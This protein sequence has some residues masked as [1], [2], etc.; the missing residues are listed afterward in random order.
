MGRLGNA[1]HRIVRRGLVG[2]RWPIRHKQVISAGL[3]LLLIVI[4]IH[5]LFDLPHSRSVAGHGIQ[6][7]LPVIGHTSYQMVF[8][9]HV[10]Q[11]SI[12]AAHRAI[13]EVFL[14]LLC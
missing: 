10:Y 3:L 2:V 1:E 11:W 4:V 8:T 9:P 6:L 5:P 7:S 13:S 14:P 12:G